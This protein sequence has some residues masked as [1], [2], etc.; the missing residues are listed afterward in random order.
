MIF[1]GFFYGFLVTYLSKKQQH[2]TVWFLKTASKT[3][4]AASES[5]IFFAK[6]LNK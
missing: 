5:S 2:S 1:L 4:F 3:A 6:G